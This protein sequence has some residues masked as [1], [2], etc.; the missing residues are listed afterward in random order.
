MRT[1]KSRITK[2]GIFFNDFFFTSLTVVL[3]LLCL[4][5]FYISELFSIQER[6]ISLDASSFIY[7]IELKFLETHK[8]FLVIQIIALFICISTIIF[9]N[10]KRYLAIFRTK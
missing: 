4:I 1:K 3:I 5:S 7:N 10:T 9:L 6:L 2:A 8:N